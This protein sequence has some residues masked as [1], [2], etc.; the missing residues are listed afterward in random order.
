MSAALQVH[1]PN[2]ITKQ[3]AFSR[4]GEV[5]KARVSTNFLSVMGFHPG[6]SIS[7]VERQNMSGFEVVPAATPE[8][9]TH[10]VY[11]RAYKGKGRS[12][13]PL[14]TVVEFSGQA[15]LDRCFPKYTERFH[16]E[17]QANRLIFSPIPNRV[18]SIINRFKKVT[19]LSAFVALTGGVDIHAMEA[20]GW[21]A[22]I[23]LEHRPEEA[24]DAAAGRRLSEVHALNTL[25]NSSPRILINEDIHHL[26]INRLESYLAKCNPIAMML[27]SL[28]CDDHSTVKSPS[29]KAKSVDDLTTMVDM[30][31]PAL[32][33]VEVV[34]PL[35]VTVENVPNFMNSAACTILEV[36]LRRMGY[37]ITRQ[38]L[39]DT[40]YGSIQGRN[41]YY[42]VAS[43]FPNFS[44]PA[45]SEPSNESI[46]PV[47]E[48]H[49]RDC[50]D[51]TDTKTI[52]ARAISPRRTAPITRRSVKCGTV[53]KSQSRNTKDAIYIEDGGRVYLPSEGL[54]KELMGIPETFNT[55]WM[56]KE[57]SIETMG[58]S[59]DYKMHSALMAAIRDHLTLNC[60]RHSIVQYG[61]Q[62]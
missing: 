48:R 43:V 36:T 24:R 28:G 15:F 45:P 9:R 54:I 38:V 53:L 61:L 11:E 17:M 33:Q 40:N 51:V 34:K 29:A 57:Q 41:R 50:R 3:L 47:V 1:T 21:K 22:E 10:Q 32:K 8:Q 31:Y 23:V 12:N 18:F 4:V 37:H 19:P 13:N 16:I 25:V 14:E 20:L 62:R 56:A 55:N 2:I 27:I 49:L 26:E 6:Q 60:G 59:V 58:Q 42:M 35:V 39:Q 46:W 7:V 30:I 44:M 5:R 52:A